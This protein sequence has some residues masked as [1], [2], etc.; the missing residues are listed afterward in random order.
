MNLNYH[1]LE[2]SKYC[3]SV[4][5]RS[6]PYFL[7]RNWCPF[8]L[9]DGHN[10][11]CVLHAMQQ[12][13]VM[14][15][16]AVMMSC[17][18]P[19]C[20]LRVK[21]EVL[22]KAGA[23]RRAKTLELCICSH[24][25]RMAP[26]TETQAA[27]VYYSFCDVP[28]QYSPSFY[29]NPHINVLRL[30][31]LISSSLLNYILPNSLSVEGFYSALPILIWCLIWDLVADAVFYLSWET[32]SEWCVR[33]GFLVLWELLDNW[34]V[35]FFLSEKIPAFMIEELLWNSEDWQQRM[36]LCSMISAPSFDAV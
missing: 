32:P 21:D 20:R 34:N 17:H 9:P 11:C 29:L 23:D 24:S 16:S 14:I 1:F 36:A 19:G 13:D 27:G 7:C 10:C 30:M 18:C 28:W 8:P 31:L 26:E 35:G 5:V 33:I 25:F 3:V 2:M 12:G 22:R 6:M 4:H 15:I